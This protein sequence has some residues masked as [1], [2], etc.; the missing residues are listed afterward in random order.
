[1]SSKA[2]YSL[3]SDNK[4]AS[5]SLSASAADASYPVSYLYDTI[6]SLPAK[7]TTTSGWFL[8]DFASAQRVDLFAIIHHNLDAG[9][10][11][12]VQMNATNT[13]G[14]PSFDQAITIPAAQADGHTTNALMDLT[15]LSGYSASGYRYL[16][17]NIAGTN[18]A[19]VA[20]GEVWIGTT[21]RTFGRN[22]DNGLKLAVDHKLVELVTDYG[23]P[24]IYDLGVTL[25]SLIATMNTIDSAVELQTLW[26]STRTRVKPFLLVPF[27][28]NT[29]PW[30]VRF[31]KSVQDTTFRFLGSSATSFEIEEVGRG[32]PL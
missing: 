26:R 19:N 28:D 20:I 1:M 9:L 2:I 15:G 11:V 21:K 30:L 13:W 17:L 3:P 18:S 29:E 5:G 14:S 25:R 8:W 10:N 4:A 7:L 31:A 22:L 24:T 27:G 23:V 12:H 16:R 6:P 32:L